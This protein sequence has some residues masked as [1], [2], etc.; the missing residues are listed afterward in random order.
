MRKCD[1][2][3]EYSGRMLFCD[4]CQHPTPDHR[5]CTGCREVK[6]VTEFYTFNT[7][8]PVLRCKVCYKADY[9]QGGAQQRVHKPCAKCGKA[10][11][12]FSTWHAVVCDTCKAAIPVGHQIC[13]DCLKA[14]PP[15]AYHKA[16]TRATGLSAKCKVC[17]TEY[18]RKN[19]SHFHRKQRQ[20][21]TAKPWI[22]F[23]SEMKRQGIL[24][25]TWEQYIRDCTLLDN[26]CQVCGR[27]QRDPA[28]KAAKGTRL[29]VDHDH[30]NGKVRGLLCHTCNLMVDAA[31]IPGALRGLE[32]YVFEHCVQPVENVKE[33]VT[34]SPV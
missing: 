7:K 16:A 28:D 6:P 20:R 5:R 2:C 10:D 32:R 4:K 3:G 9:V 12:A 22:V 8:R 25:Y 13:P 11:V 26:K 34:C 1:I 23:K 33:G 18:R 15:E 24:N 29:V 17:D 31:L 19:R 14:L 21:Y 30:Q 27:Q